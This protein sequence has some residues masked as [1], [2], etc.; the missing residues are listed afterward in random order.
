MIEV[1]VTRSARFISWQRP[2]HLYKEYRYFSRAYIAESFNHTVIF[3]CSTWKPFTKLQLVFS[4]HSVV[5]R[6]CHLHRLQ[7]WTDEQAV[8]G[9]LL[10]FDLKPQHICEY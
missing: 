6:S 4:F 8:A 10:P 1:T 5:E 9:L 2:T 7:L 3:W